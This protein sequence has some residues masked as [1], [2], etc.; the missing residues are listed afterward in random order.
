[1][2]VLRRHV[3][4]ESIPREV[5][6]LVVFAN[7]ATTVPLRQVDKSSVQRE[8]TPLDLRLLFAPHVQLDPSA[9]LKV[10]FILKHP[11]LVTTVNIHPPDLPHARPVSPEQTVTR[12]QVILKL[13]MLVNTPTLEIRAAQTQMPVNIAQIQLVW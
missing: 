4:M 10:H 12:K 7:L 8:P 2:V 13:V 5:L 3:L 6:S 1:M 11:K 9:S